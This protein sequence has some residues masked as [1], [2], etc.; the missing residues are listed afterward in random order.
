MDLIAHPAN[1]KLIFKALATLFK[2]YLSA[3]YR[4]GNS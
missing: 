2:Q 3:A 1:V 4:Y